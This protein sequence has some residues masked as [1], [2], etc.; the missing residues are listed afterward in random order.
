MC[1]QIEKYFI[2]L[3][4]LLLWVSKALVHKGELKEMIRAFW[5]FWS[6]AQ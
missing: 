2:N 6:T 3:I 1:G 4:S 5:N